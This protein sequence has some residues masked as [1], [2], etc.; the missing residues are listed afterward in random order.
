MIDEKWLNKLKKQMSS[1]NGVTWTDEQ[2]DE[3][4]RL[5]HVG[6]KVVI[7]EGPPGADRRWKIAC[8]TV[9]GRKFNTPQEMMDH[10][11]RLTK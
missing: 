11:A 8:E 9:L 10:L 5:A 3:I 7:N 4:L 2:M 1:W 6:L